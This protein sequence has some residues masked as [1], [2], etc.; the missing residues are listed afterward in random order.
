M[1]GVFHPLNAFLNAAILQAT[2]LGLGLSPQ[3]A[4]AGMLLIDLQ[5]MISHFNVEVRAG[6]L[7]FLFIGT[8]LHRTHHSAD[9]AEGKN[10]GS[11]LSVWDLLFGTFRYAPG[12]RPLA[13]GVRP[14]PGL[15]RSEEVLRVLA[16]PFRTRKS[17]AQSEQIAWVKETSDRSVI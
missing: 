5:T 8:E 12:R 10:Y 9:A 3:A 14:E 11:V 13:L 17:V 7:N 15:P 2:F 4:F 16:Y 1:H 6:W